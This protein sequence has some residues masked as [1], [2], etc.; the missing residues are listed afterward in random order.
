[1]GFQL[2]I[3]VLLCTAPLACEAI[4]VRSPPERIL[5][6]HSFEL[7][8]SLFWGGRP[9]R[10]Q[11]GISLELRAAISACTQNASRTHEPLGATILGALAERGTAILGATA[12]RGVT[13]LRV[14]QDERTAMLP[15]GGHRVWDGTQPL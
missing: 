8:L 4:F 2:L 14:V 10:F 6:H 1:M 11:G 3:K 12:E 5:H 7:T 13:M 15:A 9:P